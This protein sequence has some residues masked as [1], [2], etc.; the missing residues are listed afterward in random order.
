[1]ADEMLVVTPLAIRPDFPSRKRGTN[2]AGKA[3]GVTT[4]ML[5]CEGCGPVPRCGR[6][7]RKADGVSD[8]PGYPADKVFCRECRMT[9]KAA[10]EMRLVVW[11]PAEKTPKSS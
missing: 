2:P 10:M 1:M 9:L 7:F 8:V 11:P 5:T 4:E 6:T 3:S